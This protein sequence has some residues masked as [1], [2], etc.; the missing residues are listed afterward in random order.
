MVFPTFF[1]FIQRGRL[2][3]NITWPLKRDELSLFVT[4]QME[5]VML[6]EKSQP[7][8]DKYHLFSLVWNLKHKTS[9]FF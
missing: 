1:S 6:G 7:E 5:D 3:W 2:E 8:K 4:A 9:E